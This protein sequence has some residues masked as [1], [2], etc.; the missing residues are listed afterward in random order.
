MSAPN[1]E[2]AVAATSSNSRPIPAGRQPRRLLALAGFGLVL[3]V[4]FM[5][6]LARWARFAISS[7]SNTYLPL[8]PVMAAY[9]IVLKRREIT[10]EY[11]ASIPHSVIAAVVGLAALIGMSA[12]LE[13]IDRLSLQILALLSFLLS[14]AFVFVGA[15]VLRQIAFPIG[16]LI[17]AVPV[18]VVVTEN[19]EIFLQHA[20]ADAA[21]WMISLIGIPVVRDDVYFRFP[22]ISL[23]VARECSGYNSTLS[24]FVVSAVAGYMFLKSPTRRI[25]LCLAVIPLA[26]LRNGFRVTTLATLCVY[27]NPA[28][29]DSPIHHKGGPI[30]FAL[31]LIPFFLLLWGLRKL[32]LRQDRKQAK[33]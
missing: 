31:S 9:L 10:G 33:P 13:P 22:N 17:F 29:I 8:I 3:S 26:I 5:A 20:S 4:L 15:N 12:A 14:G 11:R 28:L 23:Q 6:S 16:L 32:E 2:T 27:V 18:P 1:T 30:F 7:E 19:I 21:S 24:L 25:I